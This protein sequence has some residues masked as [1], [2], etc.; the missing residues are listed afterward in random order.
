VQQPVVHA[1]SPVRQQ[2]VTHPAVVQTPVGP[3]SRPAARN[4]VPIA[5]PAPDQQPG[6]AAPAPVVSPAAQKSRTVNT[7]PCACNGTMRKVS[8]HWDPPQD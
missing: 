5:A 2:P 4:P 1:A 6:A 8:T 7:E 3:P